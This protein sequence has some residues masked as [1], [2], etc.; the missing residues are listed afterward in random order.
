V[1]LILSMLNIVYQTCRRDCRLEWFLNSLTNELKSY[2]G[3]VHLIIV[4]F[5][6]NERNGFGAPLPDFVT[7]TAPKPNVYQGHFK[8]TRE[9]WFAASSSRNSGLCHCKDGHVVFLDDLSVMMPGYMQAVNDAIAGNYIMCGSYS[10]SK[11]MIVENGVVKSFEPY[12]KDNRLA[13]V[14][15]DVTSCSGNFLYGCSVAG[16]VEAFLSVNGWPEAC[17]SLGGEDYC[18]GIVLKNAGW[19]LKYDRRAATMESEELHHAEKPFRREDWHFEDGKPVIGGNGKYDKSHAALNIAIQ[20][21]RFENYFGDGG[22]RALRERVLA[23]NPFPIQSI[24]EH[25]WYTSIPLRDL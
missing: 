24:P 5:Y 16:P 14:S 7:H 23:G 6:A 11:N 3:K 18:M 21:K 4:D 9:N 10:K 13:H 8:I 22:I 19:E 17:D 25:D 2:I 15:K 20:S 1:V 12:A